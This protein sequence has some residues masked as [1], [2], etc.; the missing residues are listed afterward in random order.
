MSLICAN[1]NNGDKFYCRKSM[2]EV[3]V[4]LIINE[5]GPDFQVAGRTGVTNM[6][7]RHTHA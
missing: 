5:L 6:H 1:K 2:W 7:G 3:D 4:K